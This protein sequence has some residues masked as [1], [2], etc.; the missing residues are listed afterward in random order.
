MPIDWNQLKSN[1]KKYLELGKNDMNDS[2]SIEKTA[3]IIESMYI[4]EIKKN[5]TDKYYNK[6]IFINTSDSLGL[7]ISLAKSFN[8]TMKSNNISYLQTN[9]ISTVVQNWTQAKFDIS[10]TAPGM[11]KGINNIV[12]NTGKAGSIKFSGYSS[13]NDIFADSIVSALKLHATTIVG[14][15]NGIS[16]GGSPMSIN[17]TG[18]I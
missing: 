5:A 10:N 7:H 17:W 8:N 1:I 16:I 14:S 13:S 9:A 3:R 15:Y 2:Y 12:Y 6:L 11:A 4:N 18:I